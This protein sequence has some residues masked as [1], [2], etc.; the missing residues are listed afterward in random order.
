MNSAFI[1][2]IA[3]LAETHPETT[4]ADVL[5]RIMLERQCIEIEGEDAFSPDDLIEI[6][7]K[8]RVLIH[9]YSWPPEMPVRDALRQ[10]YNPV[11][12]WRLLE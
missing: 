2:F 12:W 10:A 1:D 3:N 8:W 6:E 7:D 11:R 9:C 5:E 4:V